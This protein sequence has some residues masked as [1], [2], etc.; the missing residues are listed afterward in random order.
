MSNVTQAGSSNVSV[1]GFWNLPPLKIFQTHMGSDKLKSLE[2]RWPPKSLQSSK[3]YISLYFAS[4]KKSS[5]SGSGSRILNIGVNGISYY[6]GLNVTSDGVVV[7]ARQWPLSGPTTITLTPTANSSLGPVINAGEIFD[8]VPLGG[9]T[10]TRD[11]TYS[12][13]FF[14]ETIPPMPLSYSIYA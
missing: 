8:L 4:N 6:H 14:S 11:G 3:F 2:L 12:D 10:V 13:A 9:R 5:F 1:S 7:F